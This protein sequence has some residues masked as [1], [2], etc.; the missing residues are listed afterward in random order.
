MKKAVIS[1]LDGTLAVLGKRNVYDASKTDEVDT[2]CKEVAD[3][4]KDFKSKDY[5]IIFLTGREEKYRKP[6]ERFLK[7]FMDWEPDK[8]YMLLMRPNRNFT[9]SQLM[10]ETLYKQSIKDKF[11]V[12]VLYDD[13]ERVLKLFSED[14]KIK[15]IKVEH[16]DGV[17]KLQ[18]V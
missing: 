6:T 9:K 5:Q 12:E 2:L 16:K 17:C 13:D 15:C 8:D 11:D 10:K 1:D 18:Q 14:Y 7:K 4:L 3:K